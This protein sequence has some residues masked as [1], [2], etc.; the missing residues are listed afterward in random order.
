[1]RWWQYCLDVQFSCFILNVRYYS[2]SEKKYLFH[3]TKAQ[4]STW[5]AASGPLNIQYRSITVRLNMK[6]LARF[7]GWAITITMKLML[8]LLSSFS[9]YFWPANWRWE[10]LS[11][12]HTKH[13]TWLN[14]TSVV[15]GQERIFW[16]CWNNYRNL[17]I[18]QETL[19]ILLQLHL[20]NLS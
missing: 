5:T 14:R 1:M 7:C 3:Y 8:F 16:I 19:L 13:L 2:I 9:N 4:I 15:F 10:R 6:R 20:L 11:L 18:P 17:D 12:P